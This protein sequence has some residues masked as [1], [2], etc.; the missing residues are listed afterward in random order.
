MPVQQDVPHHVAI[1]MDGNGRWA[2]RQ[3]LPRLEGHRRGALNVRPVVE[4]AADL[5]IRQLSLFAFSSE[6]W[7]RPKAE[8]KALM[9]L[10]ATLLPKQIPEMNRQGVRALVL[11]DITALPAMAQRAVKKTCD[12]TRDNRRIDLILCLN[13]GGRQEILDGMRRAARWA[14]SQDDPESALESLDCDRFRELLWC[15]DLAP[16]DLLIRTGGEQRI[17]NFYLWDAAYAEL[18]FS[19]RCWPEFGQEDL[20]LALESFSTRERRF[21]RTSEQV[22][23]G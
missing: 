8:V 13:Y 5:G 17:S 16:V 14:Y 7:A 15:H 22:S 6:N 23:H 2:K 10:L 9:T 4:W 19:D 1:I 12:A 18:Y 11:G 3:G 21:G 20:A